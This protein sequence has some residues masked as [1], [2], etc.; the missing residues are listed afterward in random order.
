MVPI[1]RGEMEQITSSNTPINSEN[2][3]A[4]ANRSFTIKLQR[5][6]P[7]LIELYKNANKVMTPSSN[8]DNAAGIDVREEINVELNL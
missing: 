6:D 8:D 1:D 3:E 2:S 5:M 4:T 7:N